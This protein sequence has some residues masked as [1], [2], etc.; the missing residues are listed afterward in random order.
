MCLPLPCN[1]EFLIRFIAG[2][3]NILSA[4]QHTHLNWPVK[5]W[6]LCV[7][8]TISTV[9]LRSCTIH[10]DLT[11]THVPNLVESRNVIMFRFWSS[12]HYELKEQR[13]I[14]HVSHTP[15]FHVNRI[16]AII[17]IVGDEEEREERKCNQISLTNFSSIKG[18]YNMKFIFKWNSHWVYILTPKWNAKL[19]ATQIQ[20]K[21]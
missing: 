6:K 18:G 1:T 11:N 9:H 7:Q 13:S 4:K 16:G 14:T 2:I 3:K 17:L 20:I 12:I 19:N 8:T 21:C 10:S 15:V 5:Y